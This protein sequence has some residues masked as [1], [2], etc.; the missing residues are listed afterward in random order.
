[1]HLKRQQLT[2][3]NP[4]LPADQKRR[5]EKS[6]EKDRKQQGTV[7][8]EFSSEERNLLQVY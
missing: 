8:L 1:M 6:K 2:K 4:K 7:T 3:P 5:Q